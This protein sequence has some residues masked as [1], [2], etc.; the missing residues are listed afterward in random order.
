MAKQTQVYGSQQ[1]ERTF[2]VN[3]I[4]PAVK[5]K[6]SVPILSG[7]CCP[8]TPSV[9][10]TSYV[11]QSCFQMRLSEERLC[12]LNSFSCIYNCGRI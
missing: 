6:I 7:W 9:L 5:R 2:A 1:Y 3:H 8:L 10:V 11:C 12:R 4:T